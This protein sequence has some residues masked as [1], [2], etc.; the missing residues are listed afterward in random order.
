MNVKKETGTI[1]HLL[2][3][4]PQD[5]T[6]SGAIKYNNGTCAAGATVYCCAIPMVS[7]DTFET[8]SKVTADGSGNWK[9]TISGLTSGRT[10]LF[11]AMAAGEGSISVPV[12][13][14]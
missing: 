6:V 2:A 7:G 12:Q 3:P 10:Y 1:N 13:V 8:P 9:V 4:G 14:P 5:T 11:V